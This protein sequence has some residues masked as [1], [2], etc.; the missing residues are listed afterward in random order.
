MRRD[1]MRQRALLD[2]QLRT[3]RGLRRMAGGSLDG[4]VQVAA[5]LPARPKG[6]KY[7][8]PSTGGGGARFA[9]FVVAAADTTAE[10]QAGADYVCD[11]TADD[12]EIQAAIDA[13]PVGG[14]V[15]LLEG[16]FKL[17]AAIELD[18]WITL[19]GQE[20]ATTIRAGN[21][22]GFSG[23]GLINVG[24]IG[25]WAIRRLRFVGHYSGSSD[26]S[27]SA[28]YAT[29]NT[30]QGYIDSCVFEGGDGGHAI[31]CVN[32]GW[33][34]IWITDNVFS[35]GWG[36]STSSASGRKAV[37]DIASATSGLAP[38]E[39]VIAGNVFY[40]FSPDYDIYFG[41]RSAAPAARVTIVDNVNAMDVH[42]RY[43]NTFSV[44]ACITVGD[45]ILDNCYFGEV[46]GTGGS[47]TMTSSRRVDVWW[48]GLTLSATSCQ[49]CTIDGSQ[50]YWIALTSCSDIDVG[51]KVGVGS[52]V[53]NVVT[54]HLVTIDGCTDC[55][56]TGTTVKL[57]GNGGSTNTYDGVHI[58][59]SS[60]RCGVQATTVR[61]T[62][63]FTDLRHAVRV[64]A[65][66]TD[67][68][69]VDNDLRLGGATTAGLSDAGTGTI[70]RNND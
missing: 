69:V 1:V 12:V 45:L 11:G 27:K 39:V 54:Q 5:P 67:C 61:G 8:P 60:V 51:A 46:T 7:L 41:G 28:I 58:K 24:G 4:R 42:L 48:H 70:A 37:I 23:S 49:D 17:A 34:A 15:V 63:N 38:S 53:T 32:R 33:S 68:R 56:V 9:T 22:S 13:C 40:N 19:Q 3:Q 52:S 29:V 31:Y 25:E 50:E 18:D 66:C 2:A 20:G 62:L 10:G 43:V 59:G 44:D 35:N 55:N 57:N 6:E 47:V 14:T 65:G 16:T 30:H 64:E 21:W 36:T 26:P